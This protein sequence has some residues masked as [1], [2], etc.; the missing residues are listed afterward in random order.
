MQKNNLLVLGEVFVDVFI[1]SVE[2]NSIVRLGGIFN[3]IRAFSI[4]EFNYYLA[5]YSPSY[6]KEDISNYS[7]LLGVKDKINLGIIESCPNVNIINEYKESKSIKYDLILRD[8]KKVNSN[9]S[10]KNLKEFIVNNN[11]SDIFIYPGSFDS[12]S[13]LKL[14]QE[15]SLN[16]HIDFHYQS[17][18][19]I[20][21][22]SNPIKIAYLSTSSSLFLN[23]CKGSFKETLKIFN[24]K[25][26]E[27][28]IFKENRG[29]AC[30]YNN[31]TNTLTTT[32]SFIGKTKHSVGVG[33]CFNSI[34][35][36]LQYT[37][38]TKTSL[39]LAAY[40]ASIYA[41]TYSYDEFRLHC[42]TVINNKNDY[43]DL[44]G[45]R[46]S[47]DE[48]K[49]LHI[50]IAGPDF[51]GQKTNLFDDLEV[52][53]RYHNFNPHRP[54]KENGLSLLSLNEQERQE[55]YYKDL[56]LLE[57]C[58]MLIAVL[59]FND[60]GTLIEIGFYSS[61]NKKVIL[62]DPFRKAENLF[63]IKSVNKICYSL[64]EVIETLFLM[65]GRNE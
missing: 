9:F 46:L 18:D 44:I 6:L 42:Q 51:P 56:A 50:Y 63:L 23:R 49:K 19:I 3:S 55:I 33:D 4:A 61:H 52:S 45:K 26:C 38:N 28:L 8:Q 58:S 39:K 24:A 47:W 1:D 2:K 30:C 48:R 59:L 25:I 36:F 43:L 41:Q 5:Y 10:D 62:F 65:L 14:F 29:G 22:L 21:N 13:L 34:F 64:D 32:S 54:I 60:P 15:M 16:I 27:K 11:I 57:K 31:L 12:I 35:C 20:Q 53:L 40:C 37:N 17:E 7:E